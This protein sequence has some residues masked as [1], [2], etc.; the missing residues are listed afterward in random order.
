VNEKPG[1][2]RDTKELAE[3]LGTWA[4]AALVVWACLAAIVVGSVVLY[5]WLF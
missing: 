1:L 2:A 3:K 4:A 5:R